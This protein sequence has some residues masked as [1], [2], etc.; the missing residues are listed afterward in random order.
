LNFMLYPFSFREY[1]SF[2]DKELYELLEKGNGGNFLRF[3]AGEGFGPQINARLAK[4]LEQYAVY[5][6][7]PAVAL[8]ETG[9]EK[10]KILSG[11]ADN[12]LLK[13]IKGLLN[14]ATEDE[15]LKLSRLLAS[16]IGNLLNYR[17]LS[18]ASGLAY[19]NL[20]K[21]LQIL[22]K[23]FIIGLIRPY[24]TNRRTE[25]TK[26]PKN[27]FLDLGMRNY[28]LSDYRYVHVRN[29]AG[30]LMENYAF[31]LINSG[32]PGQ[33]IKYWR[34]K[35][36]AEVDFI[37]RDGQGLC[38]VE[39]KY[40]SSRSIGKSYYSFI[41][42]FKPPT[43]IIFTKDYLGQEKISQTTVKFLPLSYF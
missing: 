39:I 5:G 20:L 42:K 2:A 3:N 35:S 19:K 4:E 30:A 6:G 33:S 17:E 7:Y 10:Q 37:L 9:E 26:N 15:L 12:Y 18:A 25:L 8:S 24:Y 32:E 23:T 22:E 14:L 13:D 27:Y 31:N 16:Q 36:K 34:T 40:S 11:I 1:L 29:D 43:G 21:H 41:E 28:L 38:P